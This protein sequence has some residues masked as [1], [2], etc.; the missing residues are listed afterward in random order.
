MKPTG[1]KLRNQDKSWT[2]Y[3]VCKHCTEML[4]F[5]IQDKVSSMRFGVPVVK[6]EHK[7]HHNDCYFCMVNIFG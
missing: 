2:P 7:N 3:K 6:R 4:R 1:T 5:W